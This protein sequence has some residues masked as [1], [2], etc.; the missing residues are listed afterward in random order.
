MGL[1][2]VGR[3]NYMFQNGILKW[4]TRYDGS[5]ET[6]FRTPFGLASIVAYQENNLRAVVVE[7]NSFCEVHVDSL[8]DALK[9]CF[10]PFR[11]INP[12]DYWNGSQ[13]MCGIAYQKV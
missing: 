8:S 6:S 7:G 3:L 11:V 4:F 5:Q 10:S 9:F 12:A 13:I 1:L 2:I